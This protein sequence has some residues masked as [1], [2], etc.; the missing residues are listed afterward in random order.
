MVEVS[1][2]AKTGVNYQG[3]AI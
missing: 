1:V 3:Y 2:A